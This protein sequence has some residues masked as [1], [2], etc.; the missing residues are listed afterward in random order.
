MIK[1]IFKI[2]F[3]KNLGA[4]LSMEIVIV[5]FSLLVSS[6]QLQIPW[7]KPHFSVIRY[8][9]LK[10][11]PRRIHVKKIFKLYPYIKPAKNTCAMWG[12]IIHREK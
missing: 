8:F 3:H 2:T 4:K 7:T 1:L 5:D 6:D 10:A 11:H 12:R 9:G